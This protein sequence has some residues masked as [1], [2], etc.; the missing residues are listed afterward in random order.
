MIKQ[1][2]NCLVIVVSADVLTD[3]QTRWWQ[4]LDLVYN[5]D[6][7]LNDEGPVTTSYTAESDLAFQFV[8]IRSGII[9]PSV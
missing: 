8:Y 2:Y 4:R 1:T 9:H 6:W 3:L 7:C 5:W